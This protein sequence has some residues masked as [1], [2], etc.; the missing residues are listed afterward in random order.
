MEKLIR[1]YY[2]RFNRREIEP[3]IDLFT[4]DVIHEINQGEVEIGKDLFS[5]FMERAFSYGRERVVDLKI[6]A[7]ATRASAEFFVEGTYEKTCEGMPP[8]N[9]QK[10]RLR[11]GAFFEFEGEKIHRVTT[12]YN[13]N[14]WIAQV[15]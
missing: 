3:F 14:D 9:G 8:A 7:D 12:Y 5:T 4:E 6:F 10:F 1:E 2:E 11:C 15:S 13:L